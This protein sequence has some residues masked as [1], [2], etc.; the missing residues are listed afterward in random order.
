MDAL[1]PSS[2][3]LIGLALL[4]ALFALAWALVQQQRQNARCRQRSAGQ[5][6]T[7]PATDSVR[8]VH[9]M[10]LTAADARTLRRDWQAV[11]SRFAEQPHAALADADLLVCELLVWRG[12]PLPDIDRAGGAADPE[13]GHLTEHYRAARQAAQAGRLADADAGTMR[14]AMAHYRTLFDAL[15][16]ERGPRVRTFEPSSADARP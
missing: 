3:M 4:V 1:D 6:D 14:S 11:E 13:H 5:G 15:C 10:P 16:E 7:A 9:G 12:Y 8:G 2:W